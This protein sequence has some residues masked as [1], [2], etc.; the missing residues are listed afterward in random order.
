LAIGVAR[1]DRRRGV[2]GACSVAGRR[3]VAAV[4]ARPD[5]YDVGAGSAGAADHLGEPI[6]IE[7]IGGTDRVAVAVPLC[8]HHES[9][10][11]IKR[12]DH[13]DLI[14]R[15]ERAL[16]LDHPLW[17]RESVRDP[18]HHIFGRSKVAGVS[19]LQLVDIGTKRSHRNSEPPIGFRGD[20]D[21][22]VLAR[23][24]GLRGRHFC[25]RY[26]CVG[27]SQQCRPLLRRNRR[28]GRS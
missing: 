21:E 5:V 4:D 1:A 20:A 12:R 25:E 22:R 19:F 2:V 17:R 14:D 15:S 26:E 27:P 6:R 3:R 18:G 7:W 24:N 16:L 11:V 23:L 9:L 28:P 13:G 8:A 10:A